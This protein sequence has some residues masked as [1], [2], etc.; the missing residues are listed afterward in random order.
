[1]GKNVLLVQS[2]DAMRQML[3]AFLSDNYQVMGAK[4][5]LE[6][7]YWL[8]Q[9]HVPD[10][11][12]MDDIAHQVDAESLLVNLRCSG[13]YADIPVVVLSNEATKGPQFE[14]LGA[15]AFFSKPFNPHILMETMG[16]M[17]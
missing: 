17:A 5:G 2:H 14:Q 6:A 9:G 13:M 7:M 15:N 1:M 3:G 12:V 8:S 11:I 10:I 16:Q 4:T